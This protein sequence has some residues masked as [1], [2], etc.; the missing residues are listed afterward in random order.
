L[1]P[2]AHRSGG[3]ADLLLLHAGASRLALL[4]CFLGF[5]GGHKHLAMPATLSVLRAAAWCLTPLDL[6]TD[7]PR[8]QLDISGEM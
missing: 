4:R 5:E 8:T 6:A 3:C 1:S 7:A 2:A